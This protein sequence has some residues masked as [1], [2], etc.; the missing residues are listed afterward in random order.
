MGFIYSYPSPRVMATRA[1][2]Q[3]FE[4]QL[5]I[6]YFQTD[7]VQLWALSYEEGRDE[8]ADDILSVLCADSKEFYG[9]GRIIEIPRSEFETLVPLAT[10][11][12]TPNDPSELD[13]LP[14]WFCESPTVVAVE[15]M[16]ETVDTMPPVSE[17]EQ[18]GQ[19]WR[20]G[21][22]PLFDTYEYLRRGLPLVPAHLAA[23]YVD[24]CRLLQFGEHDDET[25]ERIAMMC[26]VMARVIEP[27]MYTNSDDHT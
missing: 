24:V 12:N 6:E 21:E 13:T 9:Y 26:D 22:E 3:R 16:D 14:E 18:L 19:Q 27:R 5:D 8:E 7:Y 20:S 17:G 1:A 23:D 15:S 10:L 4:S 2:G 11:F 25:V